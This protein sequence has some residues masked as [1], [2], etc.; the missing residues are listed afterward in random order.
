MSRHEKAGVTRFN[1]EEVGVRD[2][3]RLVSGHEK[4]DVKHLLG[5]FT[6]VRALRDICAEGLEILC[7]ETFDLVV[8]CSRDDW[9][10]AA[11]WIFY[12]S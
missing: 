8:F 2:M 7:S 11:S 4:A 3:R 1:L 12:G 5:F 10:H 6:E 9:C